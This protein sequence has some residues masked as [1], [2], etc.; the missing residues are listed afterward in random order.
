L[1]QAKLSLH[2]GW[3]CCCKHRVVSCRLQSLGSDS[4]AGYAACLLWK[5]KATACCQGTTTAVR[6][7]RA[8]YA[9]YLHCAAVSAEDTMPIYLASA[10]RCYALA[11]LRAAE[12]TELARQVISFHLL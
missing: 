5:S 10:G 3:N 9:V 12:R 7:E 2:S 1:Q 6:C 8:L 4:N 11:L